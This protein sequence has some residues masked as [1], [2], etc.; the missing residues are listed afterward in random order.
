MMEKETRYWH[1]FAEVIRPNQQLPSPEK[2][3]LKRSAEDKDWQKEEVV[4]EG[5]EENP[6]QNKKTK[7]RKIKKTAKE[8]TEAEEK[9]ESDAADHGFH[10]VKE[11]EEDEE[12]NQANE[13][14]PKVEEAAGEVEENKKEVQRAKRPDS[15]LENSSEK[16]IAEESESLSEGFPSL[17]SQ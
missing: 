13:E 10:E 16:N 17:T 12:A 1:N 11:I 6:L 4:G 2:S 5:D 9:K 14:D 3:K 7:K 8:E 15:P